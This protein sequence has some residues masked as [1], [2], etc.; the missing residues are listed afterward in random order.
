MIT[1]AEIGIHLPP[2]RHTGA[3]Y[4]A[5]LASQPCAIP[6][7][8]I[9]AVELHHTAVWH[10]IG[11]KTHSLRRYTPIPL[12]AAHHRH[13][14]YSIHSLIRPGAEHDQDRTRREDRQLTYLGARP[15][16]EL[17]RGYYRQ[18]AQARHLRLPAPAS[19]RRLA[20]HLLE[21]EVAA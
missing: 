16:A 9:R 13:A 1:L 4:N 12:C 3:G 7:C 10:D 21:L 2:I 5:W 6:S 18:Y 15:A 19:A 17:L 8:G 20:E 11:R 14:R